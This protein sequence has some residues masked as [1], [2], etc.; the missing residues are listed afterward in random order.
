M[1]SIFHTMDPKSLEIHKSAGCDDKGT[2]VGGHC[3]KEMQS[4]YD[5]ESV[6]F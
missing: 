3:Q 5:D 4:H 1:N 2:F 6:S